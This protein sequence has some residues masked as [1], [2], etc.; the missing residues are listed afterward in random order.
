MIEV[1]LNVLVKFRLEPNPE[2]VLL[3]VVAS[4][5]LLA[6]EWNPFLGDL[7]L[8]SADAIARIASLKCILSTSETDVDNSAMQNN[9]MLVSRL[10]VVYHDEEESVSKIARVVWER[11]NFAV[12]KDYL[13][14]ALPLL[15]SKVLMTAKAA[16]RALVGGMLAFP[17]TIPGALDTLIRMYQES[18][19]PREEELLPPVVVTEGQGAKGASLSSKDIGEFMSGALKATKRSVIDENWQRRLVISEC[20]AAMGV[21]KVFLGEGEENMGRSVSAAMNFIIRTGVVDSNVSVQ[22]AMVSAGQLIIDGYC[23]NKIQC[24]SILELLQF[25][26]KETPIASENIKCYDRR[27]EAAVVLLGSTGKHLN[28]DDPLIYDIL[29]GLV[30]ALNTP[31]ESVQKAVADCLVPLVQLLKTD[32]KVHEMLQVLLLKVMHYSIL[33]LT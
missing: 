11:F 17:E 6:S 29:H 21:Q 16:A 7:G 15:S 20:F 12:P 28:K 24:Q 22:S 3:D 5:S 33:L 23:D 2:K 32:D 13:H 18:L 8:L 9:T 19:P 4:G 1:C 31:V 25:T 10:W 27:H 30:D 14:D 26:L